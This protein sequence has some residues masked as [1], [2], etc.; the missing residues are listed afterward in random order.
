MPEVSV[1]VELKQQVMLIFNHELSLYTAG[2]CQSESTNEAVGFI[3]R[4][5]SGLSG[6]IFVPGISGTAGAAE[7]GVI[8]AG[9]QA[10]VHNQLTVRQFRLIHAVRRQHLTPTEICRCRQTH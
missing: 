9:A 10:C 7:T 1:D 5:L 4:D 6:S 8:L 2:E 3:A